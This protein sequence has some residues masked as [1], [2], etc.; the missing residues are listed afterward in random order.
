VSHRLRRAVTDVTAER[1]GLELALAEQSA[2]LRI[3]RELHVMTV[4][5][6]SA[7]IARADGARYSAA[8]DPGATARSAGAL[9]DAARAVQADL[10]RVMM[11]VE[12]AHL[13]ECPLT[14]LGSLT[15]VLR[16]TTRWSPSQPQAVRL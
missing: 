3:V 14:G 7:M 8:H 9:A 2:C 12:E 1:D 15:G 5:S 16:T 10:R 11:T 13:D 4:P 6:L